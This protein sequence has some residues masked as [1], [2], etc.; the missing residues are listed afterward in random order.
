MSA[1]DASVY[2]WKGRDSAPD[3]EAAEDGFLR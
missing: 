3:N 1:E 2:M